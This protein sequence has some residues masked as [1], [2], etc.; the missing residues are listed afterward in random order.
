MSIARHHAEWLSLVETSGPWL[1]M[2]VLMRVFPQGLE[3]HDPE[4]FRLLRLAYEEWE[5]EQQKTRSQNPAIHA[6]WIKFVLGSVLQLPAEAIAEGQ[7]ISQT[8][9][10]SV[11]EQGETLRPNL[12]I[13]NLGNGPDAGKPRL[14]IQ[15]YP[16]TQ[17]LIKPV[18][19]K[20]WKASP[21]TR[22]ME[23]LHATGVRL[24]LVT[25][26]EQWMVVDAPRNETTGFAS[27]YAHLW[28]EEH[29]TLQAFTSLLNA[30][31][32]FGVPD[33]DTLEAMLA[34]SAS[35]QQEVT[36]QLG[37]QVR[38]AV[39][40]LVQSLDRADQDHGGKL[41]ADIS[42]V[43]LYEAALTV[44]MRLVFLF[45]AEERGLLLLGDPIYD[46]HYAVSTLEERLRATADQHGE[47]ILE[48]RLD[49]WCRLLSTFRAVFGGVEHEQM[50]LPPYGGNLFNPDRF[51]FLEG[52]LQSSS[53]KTTSAVPL[54]VNN[55]TVLHLLDAL[56][57]LQV[58]LPGGGPAEAR[59]LSF[60]A[61]DIEQIGH[62]YEGLLDHTAKRATE[63]ML[64]LVGSK[65][66][67][68]E[69]AISRLE[70]LKAKGEKELIEFL[71]EETGKSVNAL[72]NAL[73]EEI[74][75][76]NLRRFEAVCGGSAE[77]KTLLA[78][79]KP[80]VGLIRN[81]TFGYPVVIPKG[82]VYVTAGTDR[83][84]SGT[85]YTPKSLTEPIV[86]YTLE[87]LVF[88]GPAEGKP[89]EEWIL[90]PAKELLDLKICDM[91]CG[92]GAFLV[93]AC[94]FMSER[95]LEAWELAEK[96]LPKGTPGMTP[97]GSAST[98]KPGEM[99][100]P[101]DLDER[102]VYA[103]RLIAQ[104]CLY[105]VDINPLAAEMAKLSLWLLT[106]AKDKPFTFLDHAIR[107]GDSLLGIHD[108]K[109]LKTFSLE[110]T[111]QQFVFG[112]EPLDELVDKAIELRLKIESMPS[113]TV[114]DI[115]AQ[116]CLMADCEQRVE[117]LKCAADM[118]LAAEL[119]GETPREKLGNRDN[120]AI[121]IGR[122]LK[123]GQPGAFQLAAPKALGR[124]SF[125][126]ALEFPEIV[127]ERGG[128]DA[129]V[130]NP[131]FMGGKRISGFMGVA[132]RD[133]LVRHLAAS[134][135]GNADLCTYFFLRAKLLLRDA[136]LAGLV[137]TNTIA[138]GETRAVG[139]DAM[140]RNGIVL[141]RAVS[142]RRWPGGA[143]VVVANIWLGKAV[144]WKGS[145]T[146]DDVAV[147]GITPMLT[148]VG[149]VVGPP[150]TLASN[151]SRAFI[152]SYVL[153]TGF[154]LSLEEAQ[155]LIKHDTRY[156]Q[157][158][159][160]YLNGED[161][162]SSPGQ[163]ATRWIINFFD[164]PFDLHS[165]PTSYKGPIATDFSECVAILKERVKPERDVLGLK[166]DSS[167]KGYAKYWWQYA[168][169]GIELYR[170]ISAQSH[171]LVK[172]RISPIHAVV[173]LPTGQ[174][175]NEKIVVFLGGMREFA[176]LQSSVHEAWAIEYSPTMG[177]ST[178]SYSPTVCFETFSF[179]TL[180]PERLAMTGEACHGHRSSIM[181]LRSE[182]L[183]KTYNRFHD[184]DEAAT[185][186][187]KLRDLHI[188]MDK[189][190]VA[191]YGWDDLKFGHSFH[192]TKQGI[193]FTI[194]E[195]ARREVLARLLKLNHE[196]YAEEVAQ[197]LHG[198][199]KG[200]K[201]GGKGPGLG[202]APDLFSHDEQ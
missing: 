54:P 75:L 29:I 136:G 158:V 187:Q 156:K 163:T 128:F 117:F 46:Q 108:L 24:G 193:R 22:M 56:Q 7:A 44:M 69:I 199:K 88:V 100:I 167:A 174:V 147:A 48:R 190:V 42:E 168:R 78:R 34:E 35:N 79:I 20:T 114:E 68:S 112:Q 45:C 92:S 17:A 99:L 49:A 162:N 85:H 113:N 126:W 101:K 62:V 89:K 41:L 195:L 191:A 80:F 135:K 177:Q 150:E 105:G 152:G 176:L 111:G 125:H 87:P 12:V 121:Q 32:F 171:V 119:K 28:L 94:R 116:A 175:F 133:Y 50:R 86:K 30:N 18:S 169:K 161:V 27:W 9:E 83:R 21:D 189:A 124:R 31:R 70:E 1:S 197:G 55:R 60:R 164:W 185:D 138:Q 160:P 72:T 202:Q 90:R 2:P 142:N 65:N 118:L 183:T 201:G 82:S 107:C 77:G 180:M 33:K 159:F 104:R 188:E 76:L 122:Y 64:G 145:F 154:T 36:D 172:A 58:K 182:G 3:G 6:A 146:L 184:P 71:K 10:A 134:E 132:Y 186:I 137:A 115:E 84:S 153:G 8:L 67:E 178:L 179:P 155:T 97:E 148:P 140:S 198:K 5:D 144:H 61:L 98:G 23:L 47:E 40:V 127:A 120:A 15:T 166:R 123:D 43:A 143:G 165:A 93:Q 110:G 102:K 173:A 200:K 38:K 129:F 181:K 4:R 13:K 63:P 37:Y 103:Q 106:L 51:P 91:A 53:W 141:I 194:S 11:P 14:L 139:L 157:V 151:K 73:N 196:R 19:G 95:L 131:P 59:R 52:R 16:S 192:Q 66:N 130:G 57:L 74:D 96:A 39:E 149:D 170:C 26:G 109:Q 25:N 81:D